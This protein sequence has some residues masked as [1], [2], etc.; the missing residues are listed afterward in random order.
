MDPSFESLRQLVATETGEGIQL[1]NDLADNPICSVTLDVDVPCIAVTWKRYATSAQL[2]F[3]HESIIKLL[4][5]HRV[6]KVLGDDT[7]LPTIHREDQSWIAE[8]WMP[9]AV[10]SGF[11]AAANKG[12]MSHFARVSIENV[13]SKAPHELTIRSFERIDDARE[14]LKGM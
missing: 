3:V 2:R 1:T 6:A 9:R 4:W 5:Q 7:A 11:R 12:P 14:W 10:A 8:N 13:Q